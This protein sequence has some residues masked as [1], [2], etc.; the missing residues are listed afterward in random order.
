MDIY[1][2]LIMHCK[3]GEGLRGEVDRG[4]KYIYMRYH[5]GLGQMSL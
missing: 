2:I 1:Y 4:Q 3:E 5:H